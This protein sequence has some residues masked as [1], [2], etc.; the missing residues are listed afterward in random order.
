MDDLHHSEDGLSSAKRHALTHAGVAVCFAIVAL[1]VYNTPEPL[2][3]PSLGAST[4]ILFTT[5]DSKTARWKCVVFGH[6]MTALVGL[7]V[8]QFAGTGPF[9]CALCVT[10]AIMLMDA[11]DTMHPPAAAT[12][13]IGFSTSAGWSFALVPVFCGMLV[14]ATTAK[15]VI[16]VRRRYFGY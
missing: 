13:L 11:T 15:A 5:P 4:C 1:I 3:F 14:L 10:A 9:A 2:L 12:S 6:T 8:Q 16:W 7:A